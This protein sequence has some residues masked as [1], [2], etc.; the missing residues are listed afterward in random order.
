MKD[1]G[2]INMKDAGRINILKKLAEIADELD[3]KG[4]RKEANAVTKVMSQVAQVKLPALIDSL[5]NKLYYL[6]NMNILHKVDPNNKTDLNKALRTLGRDSLDQIKKIPLHLN[7]DD[8]IK[9][10]LTGSSSNYDYY[11]PNDSGFAMSKYREKAKSY[12]LFSDPNQKELAARY[13]KMADDK[14]WTIRELQYYM[15]NHNQSQHFI[16]NVTAFLLSKNI[17]LDEN[18]NGQFE[19]W[20]KEFGKSNDDL[21]WYGNPR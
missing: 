5:T 17:N 1:A 2:R 8:D 21:R 12:D 18:L 16:N 10:R 20:A 6:D 7:S 4:L 14:K 9:S 3:V 19:F 13:L 15:G 11:D